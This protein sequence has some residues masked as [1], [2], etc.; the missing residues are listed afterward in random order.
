MLGETSFIQIC[1]ECLVDDIWLIGGY[2]GLVF[3]LWLTINYDSGQ[4]EEIPSGMMPSPS[5]DLPSTYLKNL[6]GTFRQRFR[7]KLGD[8]LS[9]FKHENLRSLVSSF[10]QT[11]EWL[12]GIRG[13]YWDFA[14]SFKTALIF[15]FI[16]IPLPAA[17][18]PPVGGTQIDP[19]AQL[20]AATL[21]LI[22]ANAIGDMV[23]VNCSSK[24]IRMALSLS[25]VDNQNIDGREKLSNTYLDSEVQPLH[26]MK[27]Y[28]FL[29][30]DLSVATGFLILVLMASSVMYGVQVGEFGL[31]CDA[32]TLSLMWESA[33]NFDRLFGAFY[34]FS[35]DPEGFL[36]RPGIPGMVVFSV[37]TFFPTL[38]IG[39]SAVIWLLVLPIRILLLKRIG[40]FSTL[41]ASQLCVFAICLAISVTT[42]IDVRATYALITTT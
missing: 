21:I 40:R 14:R 41:A 19:S 6:V 35:N 2:G 18:L 38:L 36:G 4:K 16:I 1:L 17:F 42:S 34:W 25:R 5:S 31:N 10:V 7:D 33:K 32:T 29:L 24:I 26:E 27:F 30:L 12:Y 13:N 22:L 3:L 23:S 39:M 37:T 9:F 28:V 15:Y 8:F 20:M 11:L